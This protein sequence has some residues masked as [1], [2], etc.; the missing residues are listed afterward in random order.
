LEKWQAQIRTQEEESRKTGNGDEATWN[1]ITYFRV[2]KQVIN[3]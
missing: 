2:L 3:F 1:G